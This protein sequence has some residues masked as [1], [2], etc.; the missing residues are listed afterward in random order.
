MIHNSQLGRRMLPKHKLKPYLD[1]MTNTKGHNRIVHIKKIERETRNDCR[2]P[3][4][5]REIIRIGRLKQKVEEYG[6]LFF[7]N[8]LRHWFSPVH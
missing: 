7:L 3:F 5:I 8:G 6:I 2:P 1:N 4:L